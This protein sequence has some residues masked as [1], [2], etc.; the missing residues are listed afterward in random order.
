M[1]LDADERAR[2]RRI[3]DYQ[4]GAGA[5]AA[6]FPDGETVD[7]HRTGSGRISQVRADAGR[8]VS[9][10]VD[11]RFTL[12]LAGGRRLRDAIYGYGVAVGAESEPF[13]RDGRNAFAKFVTDVDPAVR[14]RDE[15]YVVGP[16]ADDGADGDDGGAS[17]PA[18]AGRPLLAVGRAELP[19]DAMLAF[20]TGVAV[21]VREG[22]ADEDDDDG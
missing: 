8:L 12:G 10:G 13:V 19:A 22:A 4:F 15:V 9:Y 18:A 6:L 16:L 11:G 7:L 14:P 20:E 1:G 2:L 3:A 5:G 21:Q 17:S